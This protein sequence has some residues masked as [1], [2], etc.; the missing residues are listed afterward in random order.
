MG[1]WI[2]A[3]KVLKAALGKRRQARCR[4]PVKPGSLPVGGGRVSL[5]TLCKAA[6]PSSGG[7]TVMGCGAR[8]THLISFY[9]S[10]ML[11]P[12]THTLTSLRL[13]PHL[14]VLS[15]FS[16]VRLFATLWTV[17]RQAPLTMGFSRQEYWSGLPFP[18]P[19]DLPNPG[20]NTH[21]LCLLR[22]QAGPAHLMPPGKPSLSV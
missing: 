6:V 5:P 18:S 2:L 11:W 16:C 13:F 12:W 20:S 7:H 8:L 19:G 22:W 9:N 4:G 15:H 21:L 10:P 1:S 3:R 17:V 14:C